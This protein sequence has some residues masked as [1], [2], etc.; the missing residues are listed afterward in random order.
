LVINRETG[1]RLREAFTLGN[2]GN[3]ARKQ[4]DYAAAR[5]LYNQSLALKRQMGDISGTPSALE[6]L[7]EI[8]AR[9]GQPERAA[10]L[11]GAAEGLREAAGAPLPPYEQA[12]FDK[13]I[14]ELRAA[15]GEERLMAARQAGRSLSWE[16]A[17]EYAMTE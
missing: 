10:R 13:L 8:T 7:A 4:G 3:M 11:L 16:E 1:N 5:P 17:I 6:T 9:Q 2:L 12:P 15:L 14:Q